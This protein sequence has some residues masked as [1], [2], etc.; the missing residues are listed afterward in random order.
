MKIEGELQQV[1]RGESF[2]H[3]GDPPIFPNGAWEISSLGDF[4]GKP[5]WTD[6]I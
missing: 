6:I 2:S 3:R 5:K 1:G 4:F